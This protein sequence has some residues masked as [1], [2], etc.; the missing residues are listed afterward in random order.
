[1]HGRLATQRP[2]R[3]RPAYTLMEMAAALAI[4]SVLVL[5]V[6]SAMMVATRAV[7][8]DTPPRATHAAAEV[9]ARVMR[10]LEFA[11]G[12]TERAAHAVTFTV[13]DRN[14]DGSEETIRY[15]W[16]GTAGDPLTRQYN[17]G[18]AVAILN[19]VH[20]CDFTFDLKVVTE[21]PD[22][23]RNE[24]AEMLLASHQT[25]VEAQDGEIKG[26]RW[27]GQYIEPS[28]PSGAVS[29]RVTR[30]L[31]K[32][33]IDGTIKGIAGVQLRLPTAA[34]LP[35]RTILEEVT[36]HEDRLTYGYLWQE[37][38][39]GNAAGLDPSRGLCLAVVSILDD[40]NICYIQYD[41]Q[42]PG[43]MCQATGGEGTW[44]TMS[45]KSM[46]FAV[47]GTVTTTSE[48]DPVTRTWVQGAGL[49]LRAGPDPSTAVETGV[50]L[51]N[52]PG[53]SN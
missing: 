1:M 24:S 30:V 5:G 42:G 20:E 40:S 31:F 29:W 51:L 25:A 36:M 10:E 38:E 6:A 18:T 13:A 28:L 44:A 2:A 22:A 14:G 21:E 50:R 33:R 12:F 43:G 46:V 19:D 48:P 15:A 53:V 8:P 9:A 39:F 45:G 16:S 27:I 49:R 4:V 52:A 47:Y 32:A 35:S 17:G 3:P 11:T 7:E 34:N 26:N 41:N 23:E 37:F